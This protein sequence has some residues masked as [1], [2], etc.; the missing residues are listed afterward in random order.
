M[1]SSCPPLQPLMR[2]IPGGSIFSITRA[3]T[4]GYPRRSSGA[5]KARKGSGSGWSKRKNRTDDSTVDVEH[6]TSPGTLE[7]GN[8]GAA[9]NE[10]TVQGFPRADSTPHSVSVSNSE[11]SLRDK[12]QGADPG[13]AP[14]RG[15]MQRFDVEVTKS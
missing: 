1:T 10:T 2:M 4:S 12:Q 13:S 5:S 8:M 14:R 11:Q 9:A 7:L 15:I 6:L 3:R